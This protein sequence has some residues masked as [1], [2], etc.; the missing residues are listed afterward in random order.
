MELSQEQI[1]KKANKQEL[2]SFFTTHR[3]NVMHS[4]VCFINIFHTVQELWPGHGLLYGTK[5]KADN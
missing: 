5:S 3:L 2:S 4:P 1:I